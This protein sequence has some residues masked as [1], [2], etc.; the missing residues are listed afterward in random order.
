MTKRNCF[1][2]GT[3]FEDHISIWKCATCQQTEKMSK[4]YKEQ[5][6]LIEEQNRIARQQVAQQAAQQLYH[7]SPPPV[8]YYHSP[9]PEFKPE[10]QFQMKSWDTPSP[11]IPEKKY[12]ILDKIISHFLVLI[13]WTFVIFV[14][15]LPPILAILSGWIIWLL[16]GKLLWLLA[17]IPLWFILL[18]PIFKLVRSLHYNWQLAAY[19]YLTEV[20]D[21][22]DF[23]MFTRMLFYD[24]WD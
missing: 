24:T 22:R 4:L 11:S 8:Y 10:P 18:I 2:C 17:V 6:R 16:T 13:N 15:L 3:V 9:E 14:F 5:N 7:A 19:Y 20:P 21:N 1:S 12:S 23:P